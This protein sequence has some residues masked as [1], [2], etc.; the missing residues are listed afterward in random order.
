[1]IDI[2]AEIKLGIRYQLLELPHISSMAS[3]KECEEYIKLKYSYDK[4][5]EQVKNKFKLDLEAVFDMKQHVLREHVFQ[6]AWNLYNIEH[7]L[8][9]KYDRYRDLVTLVR[10][11][12]QLNSK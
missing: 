3:K 10:E 8:E 11:V 4:Q 6:M 5:L 12:E 2:I 1:M 7:G 9:V